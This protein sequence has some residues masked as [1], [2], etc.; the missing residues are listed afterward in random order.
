MNFHGPVTVFG[1]QVET[2][3]VMNEYVGIDPTGQHPKHK[4]L[5]IPDAIKATMPMLSGQAKMWYFIFR[6]LA[7]RGIYAMNDYSK[8]IDDL[9][10][11]LPD[12]LDALP[13][14]QTLSLIGSCFPDR[15]SLFQLES[16]PDG[17]KPLTFTN[18]I[19]LAKAFDLLLPAQK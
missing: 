11:W 6:P 2:K 7:E 9:K 1:D 13:S 5:S 18:G 15:K 16:A 19:Q 8:F 4:D 12:M 14:K 10:A 3:Y 17:V